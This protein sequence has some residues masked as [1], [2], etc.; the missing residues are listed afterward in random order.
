VTFFSLVERSFAVTGRGLF[1]VPAIPQGDFKPGMKSPIQLRR[2]DGRVLDTQI[3]AVEFLYAPEQVPQQ[4]MAFMVPGDISQ[5]DVPEGT[6]IW[7]SA[8][9]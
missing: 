5:E 1:I 3:E 2:P 9:E 6:E 4:R 8:E 7:L